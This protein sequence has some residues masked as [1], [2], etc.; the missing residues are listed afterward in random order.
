M[1]ARRIIPTILYRGTETFKGEGFNSWRRI[2]NLRQAVRVYQTRGVDELVLLDISGN[3]PDVKLVRDLCSECFM[4]V[5]VGGG[6]R[7]LD[8]IVVLIANG[9][10]KISLNTVVF[11]QPDLVN[12]AARKLGSQS[13]VVSID[14]K[15]GTV[16][17]RSGTVD[18]GLDPVAYAQSVER[19]GAGEIVITSVTRDGTLTGY[20][21][22]LV[23]RI[24]GAVSVPVVAAGGAG[25]YEHLKQALDAGAHAVAAGAMWSFTDATPTG[26]AEYLDRHGVPVRVRRAA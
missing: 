13:V 6:I 17:S 7:T 16:W 24:A 10:D 22:D 9:A 18:T 25:T 14:V 8:E 11:A 15:D 1:L 26:A 5:C 3:P 2:G 4:P 23:S 20:D 21:L 19:M 12:Q